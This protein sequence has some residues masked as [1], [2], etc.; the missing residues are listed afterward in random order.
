MQR[1]AS[2][3]RCGQRG[4]TFH[5][6]FGAPAVFVDEDEEDEQ[7]EAG[8]ANQAH[9][10]GDLRGRTGSSQGGRRRSGRSLQSSL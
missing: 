1:V 5:T 10:D 7:Q 8:E 2:Q 3:P 4:L 6:E 9:G